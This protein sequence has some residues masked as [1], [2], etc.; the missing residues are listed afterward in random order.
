MV[1][2]ETKKEF[3]KFAK[4]F[5]KFDSIAIPIECDFNKHPI[6]TRLCILYI[7]TMSK[8]SKEYILPFRHSDTTNLEPHDIDNIWTTKN[9]Y[10]YDKKKLLHFFDWKNT[11]QSCD[12]TPRGLSRLGDI[13][14]KARYINRSWSTYKEE[15]KNASF[16]ALAYTA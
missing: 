3:A 14:I 2:V 13:K 9:V 4:V 16:I 1:I 7:K 11:D 12:C 6:D 15:F 8:D 10:T 5:N